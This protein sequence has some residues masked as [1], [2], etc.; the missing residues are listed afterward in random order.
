L[1]KEP[2]SN[3]TI[4]ELRT[5]KQEFEIRAVSIINALGTSI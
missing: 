4:I 3:R 2:A 1:F 5:I